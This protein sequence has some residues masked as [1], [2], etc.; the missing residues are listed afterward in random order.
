MLKKIAM[1]FSI[2][3][4]SGCSILFPVPTKYEPPISIEDVAKIRLMGNPLYYSIRQKNDSGTLVGGFVV[5]HNR[6]LNIGFGRTVDMG[7]PK[8]QGK[9]YTGKYF[10]TLVIADRKAEITYLA[11]NC[12]VTLD[13]IPKKDATYEVHYSDTDLTGYCV[14]YI[15]PVVFDEVNSI[16]IEGRH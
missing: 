3:L 14:L 10:E 6:Y 7:F 4:L 11:P 16:Y 12:S 13:I 1:L 2:I 9:D 5:E 15:R 8:I